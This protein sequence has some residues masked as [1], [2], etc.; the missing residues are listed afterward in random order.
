MLSVNAGRLLIFD[1][2]LDASGGLKQLRRQ[3][4]RPH[5]RLSGSAASWARNPTTRS[6]SSPSLAWDTDAKA[7]DAGRDGGAT[8]RTLEGVRR[9]PSNP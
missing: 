2:L 3:E 4:E 7:G 5:L 6:A 8:G 9:N 1:V